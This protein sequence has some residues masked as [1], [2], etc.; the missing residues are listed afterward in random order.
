MTAPAGARFAVGW[1]GDCEINHVATVFPCP[2]CGCQVTWIPHAVEGATGQP[3]E[4]KFSQ[5][6]AKPYGPKCR[7]R[8]RKLATEHMEQAG[9]GHRWLDTSP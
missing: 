6:H 7:A 8:L 3:G 1:C 4:K 9:H 5:A 2:A